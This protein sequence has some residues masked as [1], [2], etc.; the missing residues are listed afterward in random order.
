MRL[1]LSFLG[2]LA[3]TILFGQSTQIQARIIG[4]NLLQ[5]RPAPDSATLMTDSQSEVS[6]DFGVLDIPLKGMFF[7]PDTVIT[8]DYQKYDV[9]HRDSITKI[10]TAL[11]GH[12]YWYDWNNVFLHGDLVK[13]SSWSQRN[14]GANPSNWFSEGISLRRVDSTFIG[15]VKVAP[16]FLTV[17]LPSRAK[18]GLN[19]LRFLRVRIFLWFYK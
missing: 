12:S 13:F 7:T 2:L 19:G 15:F 11:I 9:Y 3:C 6:L 18:F 16:R 5:Y 8:I 1:L 4:D 10:H 17:T 14:Y